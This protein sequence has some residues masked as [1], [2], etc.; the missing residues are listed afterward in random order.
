V[1]PVGVVVDPPFFDDLAGF[2]EIGEQ[3]LVEAL[4]TQPAVEAFDKPIL[5]RLAGC[6]VV[7]LDLLLVLPGQYGVRGEVG[8]IVAD[9]HAWASSDL[10]DVVKF[11]HHA[12]SGER[13]V[14]D[15]AKAFPVKS[16]TTVRMRKRRPPTGVSVTKSSD[17]RRFRS[18]GIAIGARVPSARLRPPR[19]RID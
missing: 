8:A 9:D 14:H 17:Q 10:D 12:Q 3:L 15:Q 18:C 2:V 1:R 7:P 4:V 16:S 19:L 13:G 6:D 11:T 5:H